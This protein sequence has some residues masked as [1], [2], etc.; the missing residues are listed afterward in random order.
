LATVVGNKSDLSDAWI[1]RILGVLN[2][3]VDSHLV[4]SVEI[5]LFRH[6]LS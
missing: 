5:L 6:I 1:E 4:G 2:T 3:T